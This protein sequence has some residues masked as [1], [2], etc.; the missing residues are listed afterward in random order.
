MKV[1]KYEENES[2]LRRLEEKLASLQ[3]TDEMRAA[4]LREELNRLKV[5]VESARTVRDRTFNSD[6]TEFTTLERRLKC[7]LEQS[8][9]V[10]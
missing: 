8:A 2:K 5:V 9:K 3:R 1:T 10:F 4:E 6:F 7:L